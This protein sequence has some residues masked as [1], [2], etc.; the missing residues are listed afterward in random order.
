MIE[1]TQKRGE[2]GPSGKKRPY[3]ES[4]GNDYI[5]NSNGNDYIDNSN[6]NDYSDEF[7][8]K[9][10]THKITNSRKQIEKEKKAREL[11]EKTKK[12]SGPVFHAGK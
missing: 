8:K 3:N 12:G 1:K 6:G 10:T 11:I 9:I 2:G 7:I 5:D 4:N